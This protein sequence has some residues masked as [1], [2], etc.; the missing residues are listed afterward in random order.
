MTF[1]DVFPLMTVLDVFSQKL[2]SAKKCDS[3]RLLKDC[4]LLDF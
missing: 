4:D 1:L 3:A 2:H